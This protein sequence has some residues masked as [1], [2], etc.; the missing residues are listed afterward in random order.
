M[1]LARAQRFRALFV[2]EAAG[3]ARGV[4]AGPSDMALVTAAGLADL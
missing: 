4:G 2:P 3:K 1:R